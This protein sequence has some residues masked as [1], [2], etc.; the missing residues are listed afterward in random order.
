ML[1]Y[2]PAA[3]R[4]SRT[5][6]AVSLILFCSYIAAV[7]STPVVAR[8][9]RHPTL[10]PISFPPGS[11]ASR[12]SPPEVVARGATFLRYTELLTF[13][14]TIGQCVEV[15]HIPQESRA[16][17]CA[18]TS[19]PRQRP[20]AIAAE[21]YSGGPGRFGVT[22][23]IGTAVGS[24][25]RVLVEYRLTGRWHR[26]I[27]LLTAPF[28]SDDANEASSR[29]WFTSDI[30]GCQTT[31]TLRLY[32]VGSNHR[33]LGTIRGERQRAACREGEGFSVR[34]ALTFGALPQS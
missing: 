12:T 20:L 23:V 24:A 13:S 27:A 33:R 6:V 22:E 32:A 21:G 1:S 28:P 18:F 3:L 25:S 30:P 16:G 26:A 15:D 9:S 2:S 10:P 4:A 31:S 17:G 7:R 14:S 5:L 19:V 11:G 8:T 34:A 29:R